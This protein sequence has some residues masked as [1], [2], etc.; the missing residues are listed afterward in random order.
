M[1]KK[2]NMSYIFYKKIINEQTAKLSYRKAAL[3]SIYNCEKI[4]DMYDLI[5]K[6]YH[7]GNYTLIK[8]LTN[9]IWNNLC[10]SNP[11]KE[12]ERYFNHLDALVPD[13][14]KYPGHYNAIA[15]NVVICLD[16]SYKCLA[17]D[18]NNSNLSGLYV[19]DTIRQVLLH[20][21]KEIKFI[22]EDI[23]EK[24]DNTK[25]VQNE[26]EDEIKILNIISN[27]SVN[28]ENIDYIYKTSIFKK[29]DYN[30]ITW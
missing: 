15:L 18:I 20:K 23:I 6:T 19:Y 14:E 16:V 27:F 24:I 17:K 5:E 8:K 28:Q 1:I 12:L 9:Y 3:F 11:N 26:I 30:D 29:Y 4:V 7:I 21:D 2:Y 25:V 10:S 22:T 13:G